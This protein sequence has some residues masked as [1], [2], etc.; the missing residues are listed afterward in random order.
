MRKRK[1]EPI[2]PENKELAE[3]VKEARISW[4]KTS[5]FI[6][7][8]FIDI[9]RRLRELNRTHNGYNRTQNGDVHKL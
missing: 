2:L 7:L 4:K 9:E 3:R 1:P 8:T 5:E 6:E